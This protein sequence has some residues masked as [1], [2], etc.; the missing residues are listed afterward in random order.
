M[1]KRDKGKAII[2][3]MLVLLPCLVGLMLWDRLPEQMVTNWDFSG[4]P[5]DRSSRAFAVFGVPLFILVIHLICLVATRADPKNAGQNNKVLGMLFWICPVVSIFT[6][7][8]IY[9]EA[10]GKTFDADTIMLLLIGLMF[11]I[12]GNYLPKCKQNHTIGIKIKWTLIN[13]ENW[14]MTHRM[15][16]RLWVIG[17]FGIMGC[18]FLPE[19]AAAWVLVIGLTVLA[20]IPILYSFIY[21]KKSMRKR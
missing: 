6:S 15:A 13:E 2:S 19:E 1:F 16:G 20:V 14:N 4:T 21:Y 7:G 11:A 3:S 8:I 9:A 12:I 5:N 10:L 17:G 18:I